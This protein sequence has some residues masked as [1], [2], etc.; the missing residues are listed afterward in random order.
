[1][2][3][4]YSIVIITLVTMLIKKFIQGFKIKIYNNT[5][6]LGNFFNLKYYLV[7]K[8]KI[9]KNIFTI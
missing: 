1:M 2:K 3:K 8:K 9:L 5:Y 4:N 7:F 6:I